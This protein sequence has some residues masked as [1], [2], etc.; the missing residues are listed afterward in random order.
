[1]LDPVEVEHPA[2]QPGQVEAEVDGHQR[3]HEQLAAA[4]APGELDVAELPRHRRRDLSV[5]D[6]R[7][8][9]R[10]G[11][12][13]RDRVPVQGRLAA[14]GRNGQRPAEFGPVVRAWQGRTSGQ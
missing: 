6:A 10:G 11:L 5:H 4:G 2:R 9:R 1:V 12:S 8:L 14:A 13:G 7:P 3:V